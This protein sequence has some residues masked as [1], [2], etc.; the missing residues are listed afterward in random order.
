MPSISWSTSTWP[1]TPLPAPMPITGILT[2]LATRVASFAGIFSKTMAK[3][4]AFMATMSGNQDNFAVGSDV[5]IVFGGTDRFD[6]G[7]DFASNTFTAPA[8]GNYMINYNIIITSTD[9]AATYYSLKIVTSNITYEPTII[10]P[11]YGQDNDYISLSGS[12]LV[13][14]DTSDTVHLAIRQGSG[15]Q[16]TDISAASRFSGFLAC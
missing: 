10:D 5:T 4:P 15:T 2:S 13:D 8:S 3:Q 14:M 6:Q 9:S 1:S 7:G 11:D 16:Q 12:Q